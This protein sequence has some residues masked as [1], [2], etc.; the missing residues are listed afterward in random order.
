M[1]DWAKGILVRYYIGA[2]VIA[3]LVVYACNDLVRTITFPIPYLI[4][5]FDHRRVSPLVPLG[6]GFLT[7]QTASSLLAATLLV[8]AAYGL[9]RWLY[10]GPS[11]PD[12]D[13]PIA[14]EPQDE[15]HRGATA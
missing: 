4:Q 6:S 15:P 1:L 14:D 13:M 10:G 11:R 2:I 7:G 3:M 9:A 5:Y 8:A 12:K